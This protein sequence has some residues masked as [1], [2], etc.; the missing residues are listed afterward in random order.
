[1]FVLWIQ[2]VEVSQKTLRNISNCFAKNI[3]VP[4]CTRTT[5]GKFF[6]E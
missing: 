2:N 1:M 5:N 6:L 3:Y 4:L